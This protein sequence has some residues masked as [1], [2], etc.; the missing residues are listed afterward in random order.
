MMNLTLNQKITDSSK[1]SVKNTFVLVLPWR[2]YVLGHLS[3]AWRKWLLTDNPTTVSETW[4][5]KHSWRYADWYIWKLLLFCMRMHVLGSHVADW[6]GKCKNHFEFKYKAL[7]ALSM[8]A[9]G[10][11]LGTVNYGFPAEFKY[12]AGLI[13]TSRQDIQELVWFWPYRTT[14][15]AM[16]LLAQNCSD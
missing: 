5:V 11:S 13:R 12:S 3:L 4:K 1:L 6:Y 10:K 7:K 16:K 9:N 14:C 15:T 8:G 2:K